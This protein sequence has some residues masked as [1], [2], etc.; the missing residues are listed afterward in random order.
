MIAC[1]IPGGM[2]GRFESGSRWRVSRWRLASSTRSGDQGSE[3]PYIDGKNHSPINA[4]YDRR[5]SSC[6]SSIAMPVLRL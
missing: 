3:Q 6:D 5:S 4:S 2:S 1:G